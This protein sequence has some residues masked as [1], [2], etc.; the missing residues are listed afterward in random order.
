MGDLEPTQ[1]G[2][3]KLDG[4]RIHWER[5]GSGER[6]AVCLLNG[7]AMHTRAWYGL[8]PLVHPEYDVVLYDYLGQGES[9]KPDEP[10]SI[11][12]LADALAL[13]ADELGI[14][15]LHVMGISYGGFVALEFARQHAHRLHTL[16]LSG[17]LLFPEE[18][19]EMYE[20]MS[21][22]FYRLGPEH[23]GLYTHYLYEKI[24]GEAFVRKVT[25]EGLEPM[26]AR[27]EERFRDQIHCLVRLTEAQDPHFA[28]VEERLPQYR[29][30]TAPVLVMPGEQDRAIPLWQQRKLL[31]V[32][33]NSRWLPIPECGH[34]AYLEQPQLFFGNLLAFM[35]ARSTAF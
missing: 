10:Y 14:G 2:F 32:F 33:P 11:A 7:L 23:F 18:L 28:A 21:L 13:I 24:F 9:D 8:L 34:V 12:R 4:H 29:A 30:V 22:R 31:E 19:F 5:F 15:Q 25:R 16:A 3:V 6:E 35:R 26:R 27:F 20:A 17:I 1:Q